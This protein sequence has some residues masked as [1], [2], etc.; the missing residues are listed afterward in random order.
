MSKTNLIIKFQN[1]CLRHNIFVNDQIMA[2]NCKLLVQ[3]LF[4]IFKWRAILMIF[5]V[6]LINFSY[7]LCLKF[8]F[9]S[10]RVIKILYNS[11]WPYVNMSLC[12]A[13][14]DLRQTNTTQISF[15]HKKVRQKTL[16][17]TNLRNNELYIWLT[18]DKT[19]ARQ[20]KSL[21]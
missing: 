3:F 7:F 20:N 12:G 19:N 4:F 10:I 16:D 21:T 17:I 14:T 5:I 11:V 18:G 1:S 15:R 2:F 6:L 8:V 13:I 9:S